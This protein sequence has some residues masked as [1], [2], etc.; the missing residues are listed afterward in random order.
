MKI[1]LAIAALVLVALLTGW[2]FQRATDRAPALITPVA[3]ATPAAPVNPPA[4]EEV[5]ALQ[6]SPQVREYRE[7][8][9]FED[10]ARRFLQQAQTLAPA[11]R[12]QQAQSLQAQVDAYEQSQGLSAGEA[13]LLRSGLIDATVADEAQRADRIAELMQRYR[14][15]SAQRSARY[16]ADQRSDP[17]FNDYK[18]R[19]RAI[20]AEVAAMHSVPGG[21]TR[22][23]YLRQRLQAERERIYR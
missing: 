19:E 14:V 20:V 1:F 3:N 8:Q 11:E 15:A 7:R 9:A 2:V 4:S 23:E 10:R 17:R 12:Q 13:L 18:A 22:D 16:L 5:A 21:L 6:T